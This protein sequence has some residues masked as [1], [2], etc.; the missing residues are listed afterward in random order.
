MLKNKKHRKLLIYVTIPLLFLILAGGVY[1]SI[2]FNKAQTT[3]EKAHKELDRGEQSE[4]RTDGVNPKSD[5]IS[6]LLMGV[7]DSET[8]NIGDRLGEGP[9]TDA[10]LL[11]TFNEN[12]KSV[13]LVHIPRDSYVPLQFYDGEKHRINSA[14]HFGLADGAVQTVEEL[15]DIPVD[16]YATVNFNSFMD[17]VDSLNGIE[18]DVPVTFTEQDSQDRSK[19]IHLEKGLQTLNGEEALALARTRKIDTDVERGKRQQLILEAIVK[20]AASLGSITKYGNVIDAI[21]DNIITNLTFN[22]MLSFYDY[23]TGDVT[24]ETYTVPGYS[25][26]QYDYIVD[27]DAFEIIRQDLKAHLNIET[28]NIE[29]NTADNH[30]HDEVQNNN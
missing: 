19:A 9:R 21:G 14:Y 10:L 18:V 20:K 23:A 25:N 12:K 3:A 7:D 24:I 1:A 8:R 30:S 16:Y 26:E 17:I 15:F 4:R 2:L 13:K 11:A 29:T 5:N 6:I 27:Y 28:T 22:E